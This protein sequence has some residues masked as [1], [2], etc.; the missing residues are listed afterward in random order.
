MLEIKLVLELAVV[1]VWKAIHDKD[2]ATRLKSRSLIKQFDVMY[3]L[4]YVRVSIFYFAML[5]RY[6]LSSCVSCH[7][8]VLLKR[9]NVG[10]RK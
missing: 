8:P 4:L 10:S 9:L 2:G 7:T 3:G 5:A 1:L 6:M